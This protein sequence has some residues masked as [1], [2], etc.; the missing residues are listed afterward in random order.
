MFRLL[1]QINFETYT[2]DT[3][4]LQADGVIL[5]RNSYPFEY[6][7]PALQ[8]SFKNQVVPQPEHAAYNF[9]TA[10][11]S[12]LHLGRKAA[13]AEYLLE[14]LDNVNFD[15]LIINGD[16]FDG[17]NY[18]ENI[19]ELHKRCIDA[20]FAFIDRG[21]KL[22]FIPGNHDEEA[23]VDKMVR[24]KGRDGR[25]L[26]VRVCERYVHIDA[27]GDKN[28]IRHGHQEDDWHRNS[29]MRKIAEF[30]DNA[31]EPSLRL[32][33]SFRRASINWT[34]RDIS[35]IAPVKYGVKKFFGIDGKL[36]ESM[37]KDLETGLYKRVFC[38]HTHH[39]ELFERTGNSGNFVENGN[40]LAEAHD[41]EWR[42]FNWSDVRKQLNLGRLP[43]K[44]D[45]NPHASYRAHTDYTLSV[46]LKL[47]PKHGAEIHK[48]KIPVQKSNDIQDI[49]EYA[50][51]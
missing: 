18:D 11:I 2:G 16:G 19:P 6:N 3:M 9:R 31:Y 5:T 48:P 50:Y 7:S 42:L 29:I 20:M 1:F 13:F 41:G 45:A 40:F 44:S 39:A 46:F 12:D 10:I 32:S 35:L 30:A 47:Y 51:A 34:G 17:L 21:G 33:Q 8:Q 23:T 24:I 37:H 49:P 22:V 26:E 36:R 4:L 38:G 14:F 43:C 25:A 15:K 28:L 27:K